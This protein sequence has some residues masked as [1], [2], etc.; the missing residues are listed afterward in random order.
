MT[1]KT[2]PYELV[3]TAEWADLVRDTFRFQASG[4][5]WDY[6]GAC[7]RCDHQIVKRLETG[8]TTTYRLPETARRGEMIVRCNCGSEHSGRPDGSRG[9]GAYAAVEVEWS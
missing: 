8:G 2:V 6:V 3:S 9:C 7:P 5:A 4:D 1:D